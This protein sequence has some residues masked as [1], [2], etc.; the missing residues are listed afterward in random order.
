MAVTFCH[1]AK[2]LLFTYT[3]VTSS[4]VN[5]VHVV[6]TVYKLDPLYQKILDKHDLQ[7]FQSRVPS[8]ETIPDFPITSGFLRNA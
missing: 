8:L 3:V 4:R 1:S 5:G 7:T 6:S 2:Y